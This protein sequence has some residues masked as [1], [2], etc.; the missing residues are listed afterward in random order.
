[1]KMK[2]FIEGKAYMYIQNMVPTSLYIRQ[3]YVFS[4]KNKLKVT[5]TYINT[6]GK[7]VNFSL[8]YTWS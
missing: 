6:I 4:G 2:I 8:W 7:N 5:Y 3:G 1:M